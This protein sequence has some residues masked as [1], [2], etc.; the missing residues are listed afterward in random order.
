MKILLQLRNL[1]IRKKLILLFIMVGII[2]LIITFFVSQHEIRKYALDRQSYANNQT[3]EQ[4]LSVLKGR[5]SHIEEIASMI[6]VNKDITSIFS[7]NPDQLEIWKQISIFEDITSYTQ[8]LESDSQFNNIM[9]FINDRFVMAGK[10]SLYR[11]LSQVQGQKWTETFLAAKGRST[12][13][14][15]EDKFNFLKPK[16]YLTLGRALW[17][18]NNYMESVGFVMINIDLGQITEALQPSVPGQLVYVETADGEIVA[19]SG[20]EEELAKIRLPYKLNSGASYSEI[21]LDSGTYLAR[22]NQLDST[23]LYLVS[24]IPSRAAMS[25]IQKIRAQMLSI[26]AVIGL[27]IVA[28]IFPITRSITQRIF[29]LMNKM[30]QVRQGRLNT[31]DLEPRTDELGHLISSYNYMINSVQEL[32]EEQFRLGQEKKGAELKALQSQINPHFLYNTLDMVNWMAQKDEV[33]NIQKVIHA[34]SDYYKL[35]LN[36]GKDFVTVG[37][38]VRMCS[39]YMEIQKNRYKDRIKLEVR[40]EYE[41]LSCM[42]PKITLQP[43]I[44]N[45]IVHGI[46][47]TEERRG[48]IRINGRLEQDRLIVSIEDNGAGIREREEPHSRYQGSGYGVENINKRLNLFFGDESRDIQFTST[49]GEGTCVMINVPAVRS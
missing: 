47:E 35:V 34:L 32:M 27:F 5:M 44:E 40:V 46:M 29:L 1:S 38:E 14:I 16:K 19:S 20:G 7:K 43:L 18:E 33:E 10:S 30:S 45:A 48:T 24:V 9:Y 6:V 11:P 3:Y 31:L 26:Y 8:I 37:D 2:P 36:K 23:G 42:L 17:N 41:A 13:L 25:I 28:S 21:H 22:G 49:E 12:W 15:F 39:I 4:T